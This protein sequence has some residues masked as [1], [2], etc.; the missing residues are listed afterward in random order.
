MVGIPQQGFGVRMQ[1][2]LYPRS[3]L[4]IL[5]AKR[6]GNLLF[7]CKNWRYQVNSDCH[8]LQSAIRTGLAISFLYV[9]CRNHTLLKQRSGMSCKI[10]HTSTNRFKDAMVADV[11]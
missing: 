1:D 2:S 7:A 5:S 10:Q 4:L 3:H 6:T 11:G 9:R 8:V